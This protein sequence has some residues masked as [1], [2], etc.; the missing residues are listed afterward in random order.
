M[1]PEI[2][3]WI[4]KATRNDRSSP[5]AYETPNNRRRPRAGE[6]FAVGVARNVLVAAWTLSC[7]F[8][9]SMIYGNLDAGWILKHVCVLLFLLSML[10]AWYVIYRFLDLR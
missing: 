7:I 10:V 9:M 8:G 1:P 4:V 5:L 6:R 2:H 3:R